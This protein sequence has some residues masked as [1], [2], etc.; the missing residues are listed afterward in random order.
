MAKKPY[1][2]FAPFFVFSFESEMWINSF[3][4][5]IAFCLVSSSIYLINDCIDINSDKKHQQRNIGLLLLV[6][7]LKNLIIQLS[8]IF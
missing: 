5:F 2:F 6:K 1:C 4:A 3:K 7:F 8:L